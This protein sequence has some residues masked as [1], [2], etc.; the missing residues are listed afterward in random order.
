M[1]WL[2]LVGASLCALSAFAFLLF[3][4][5]FIWSTE[6]TLTP[7]TRALPLPIPTRTPIIHSVRR[8]RATAPHVGAVTYK[9]GQRRLSAKLALLRDAAILGVLLICSG[10]ALGVIAQL[11]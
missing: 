4:G 3:V 2:S 11:L 7:T 6:R 9:F 10:W 5:G 1:P 8:S